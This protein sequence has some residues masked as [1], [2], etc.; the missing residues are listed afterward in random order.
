MTIFSVFLL[1]LSKGSDAV[2]YLIKIKRRKVTNIRGIRPK[3]KVNS[4][5]HNICIMKN[6][7]REKRAHRKVQTLK[8]KTS[9]EMIVK[10][11]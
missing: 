4:Q 2:F 11:P 8:N 10:K 7:T 9:I 5:G 6:L 3:P 1:F